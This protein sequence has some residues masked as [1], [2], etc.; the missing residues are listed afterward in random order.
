MY[1]EIFLRTSENFQSSTD[2]R[3]FPSICTIFG[4][5]HIQPA[6]AG[7]GKLALFRSLR[8]LS[9]LL[10]VE[11]TSGN[12]VTSTLKG[13]TREQF[14]ACAQEL[15]FNIADE[16]VQWFR[17]SVASRLQSLRKVDTL[18]DF[19][20]EVKYP[21]TPGTMGLRACSSMALAAVCLRFSCPALL[22]C[23]STSRFDGSMAHVCL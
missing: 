19:L 8:F 3:K 20:P 4:L 12:D 15:G 11:L 1:V 16:D 10:F 21:R 13:P 17:D 18:P 23:R 7:L 22:S 14:C 6:L 5:Q 2:K 9:Y